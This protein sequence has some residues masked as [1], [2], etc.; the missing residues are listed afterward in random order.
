[1]GR[2]PASCKICFVA[3]SPLSLGILGLGRLGSKVYRVILIGAL[4]TTMPVLSWAIAS[5]ESIINT[6]DELA[7]SFPPGMALTGERSDQ[8]GGVAVAARIALVSNGVAVGWAARIRAA[9]PAMCG[10]A[11]LLPV[12]TIRPPSFQAT[13]TSRP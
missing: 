11:K 7:K 5:D 12:A 9:K 4:E 13:S 6:M 10:A 1:M 2:S 3:S 8:P